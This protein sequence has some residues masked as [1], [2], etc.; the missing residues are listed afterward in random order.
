MFLNDRS[1]KFLFESVDHEFSLI[2]NSRIPATKIVRT[3]AL[4]PIFDDVLPV[5]VSVRASDKTT[6]APVRSPTVN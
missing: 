3:Q 2:L 5:L 1:S 6:P 4:R